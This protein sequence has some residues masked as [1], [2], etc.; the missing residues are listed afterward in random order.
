MIEVKNSNVHG[1]GVFATKN[2]PKGTELCCDVILI[3]KELEKNYGDINVYSFPWNKTHYSICMGFATFF[4]HNR[5]PNVKNK[6]I[7]K[8]QLKDYFITLID[9]NIGDEL[10]IDYGN[11]KLIYY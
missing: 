7:D 8:E 3:E 1:S 9:I 11:K 10:F 5:I 6:R 2:I 4:N